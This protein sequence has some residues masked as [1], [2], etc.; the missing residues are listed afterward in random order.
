MSAA[1]RMKKIKKKKKKRPDEKHNK[2]KF[3]DT[4]RQE[5]A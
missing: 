4:D 3:L 2:R 1:G 5:S